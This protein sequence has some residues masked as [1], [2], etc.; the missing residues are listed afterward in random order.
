MAR[1]W[2]R[3]T[4]AF[5]V[6]ILIA[7]VTTT[8]FANRRAVSQF[9]EYLR[10]P[11]IAAHSDL[12]ERL[13]HYY[14]QRGSWAGLDK[15][16]DGLR[17]K[18]E[19]GRGPAPAP[20]LPFL[21]A[22]SDNRIVYDDGRKREGQ[23]LTATERASAQVITVD[24]STVGYFVWDF[25]PISALA[26]PELNFLHQLRISLLM[27]GLLAGGLGLGFG[28][29]ISRTLAAPLAVLARTARA[30]A[31]QDWNQR[32]A[33]QDLSS[34]AEVAEVGHAFN[35]MAGALQ[36]AE[37]LRRNLIADV[38]HE[39]RTPLSVLQGNLTALLD[40]L[41]PL[42]LNEIAT[43]YDQTRLLARL[44]DD[45][46]ELAQAEAGQLPLNLHTV[47]GADLLHAAAAKFA[48]VAD[49]QQISLTVDIPVALPAI[50]V[51]PDR[52]NQ[53]L[54]NLITNALHHTPAG[55]QISLNGMVE[56]AAHG[57][58]FSVSDT[59]EGIADADLPYVFERFYRGD[60]SRVRRRGGTGLGLTI[61]KTLIEAMH[62]TIGVAS[63]PGQGSRFWFTVP[64]AALE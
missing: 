26:T 39:L 64:R 47:V 29:V 16:V 40:G 55:G 17:P 56:D 18:H 61:A 48:A 5:L 10:R 42:D 2:V 43:L 21:L 14:Q 50:Y 24:D 19:P 51:D 44:V 35:D 32:V 54:Q 28:L 20:R 7:V 31:A 34:I 4:L 27:A 49:A 12:P 53:V 57:V 15:R 1:L 59:G 30:F 58:Y 22:D 63:T 23:N 13:T 45:L 62:G 36:H 3:L 52:M 41:Y 11:N 33:V 25:V 38:A 6:V 60:K 46:R 37:T 8:W 9:R